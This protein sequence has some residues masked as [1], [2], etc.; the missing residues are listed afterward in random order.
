MLQ[1]KRLPSRHNDGR[2][3]VA[4]LVLTND[5]NLTVRLSLGISNVIIITDQASLTGIILVR[6]C[7]LVLTN[8]IKSG[9][10]G[11]KAAAIP[12]NR[13]SKHYK[14]LALFYN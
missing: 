8:S 3:A 10:K 11:K 6:I 12:H 14:Q 4:F 5:H 9:R 13:D 2:F 1:A 7:T